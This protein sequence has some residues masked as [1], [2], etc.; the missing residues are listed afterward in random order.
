MS[1]EAR[2][3]S[4]LDVDAL[5]ALEDYDCVRFTISDIYGT[6]RCRVVPMGPSARRMFT[7]GVGVYSGAVGFGLQGQ[8]VLDDE[9]LPSLAAANL[10]SVSMM[11]QPGTLTPLPWAGD[12]RHRVGQVLCET[13][14]PQTKQPQLECP[15]FVARR[16]LERLAERGLKLFS[17]FEVELMLLDGESHQP[18]FSSPG[19][20]IKNSTWFRFESIM[21]DVNKSAKIMGVDLE[22][23]QLEYG[24]SQFELVTAPAEGVKAADDV[25]Y[26]KEACR[27]IAQQKN[28]QTVFMGKPFLE[29]C[30]NGL[31]YSHSLKAIDGGHNVMHAADDS[32]RLS[33]VTRH[34]M[35]GLIKHSAALV[36]L[37]SPTFNCY[38]RLFQPWAPCKADW[39]VDDRR[40]AFR[41]R[42]HSAHNTYIESRLPS[43]SANPYIVLAATV[44]AGMDGLIN[45]LA[46][47]PQN[48]AGASPLPASL[49]DAIE[50]LQQDKVMVDALGQEFINFFCLL[51]TDAELKGFDRNHDVRNKALLKEE[52]NM[53]NII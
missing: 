33:D 29:G 50:A 43:G 21:L 41:V 27:E 32:E 45:K 38:R 47:P 3:T 48:D 42:N 34:W 52:W 25:F 8:I 2:E 11:P 20:Y 28:L 17:G 19:D 40:V 31:H 49:Q 46:C 7:D 44:A 35:A 18:L 37:T 16:Q 30:G 4:G 53:Y 10:G 23:L 36:A 51:K 26:V 14:W 15:R 22:S 9:K 39:A 12:G 1:T 13:I 5:K 6:P 24:Q